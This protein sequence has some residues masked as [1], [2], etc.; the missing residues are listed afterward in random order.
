[1]SFG[2]SFDDLLSLREAMNRLFEDSYVR[3]TRG[4]AEP[5]KAGQSIPVNIFHAGDNVVVFAP[6]PGLHAEDVEMSVSGN[7]LTIHGNKRGPGEE[8]RQFLLHE[9]TVGPYHRVVE[10]PED[11]EAESARASLDNGVLVVT[12][13]KSERNKPRR[14]PVHARGQS[15]EG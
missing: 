4:Q 8:R 10:L 15:Q 7:M 12:F 2:S 5:G 9:W 3:P 6:M 14:I 13:N 1:M 11:V